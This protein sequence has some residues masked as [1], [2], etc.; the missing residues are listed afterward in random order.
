M[1]GT[2]PGFL[3]ATTTTTVTATAAVWAPT[4]VYDTGDFVSYQGAF[5]KPLWYTRN[6]AP[7]SKKKNGAWQE[8]STT[9]DGNAVWTPTR[10][11]EAGDQA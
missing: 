5:W 2:R 10:V 9:D 6:E 3:D 8:W 11:F 1:T 4:T 7:G